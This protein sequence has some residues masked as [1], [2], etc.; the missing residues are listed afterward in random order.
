M[1]ERSNARL[2]Y[3]Y[4]EYARLSDRAEEFIKSTID[5]FKLF[6]AVGVIIIIWKP[7]SEMIFAG[8]PNVDSSL[9]L[10]IGF[11]SLYLILGIIGLLNLFKMSY[12]WHFVHN[13]K[14]YE[15][16]IKK[17]LNEAESSQI[18]NFN[19][20]KEEARFV[21]SYRLTYRAF[22]LSMVCAAILLPFII[23]CYSNI[24]YAGLYLLLSVSGYFFIYVQVFRRMI[25]QYTNKNYFL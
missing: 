23:L 4:K 14:A 9:V 22:A 15:M 8:N 2:E 13:L 6:G 18:F 10:F 25:R 19:T 3:L 12:V 11:L 17:E 5:D 21:T 20:G 1:E 16:E 7:T 24:R